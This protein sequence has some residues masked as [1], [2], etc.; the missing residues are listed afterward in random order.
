[1]P[2]RGWGRGSVV[3]CDGK[4]WRDTAVACRRAF[5]GLRASFKR[6][7]A[8]SPMRGYALASL[9]P[10]STTLARAGCPRS[11]RSD[12]D[13]CVDG[14]QR[15]RGVAPGGR[16]GD[17]N[18]SEDG[19]QRCRGVAHRKRRGDSNGSD[20]GVQDTLTQPP[21]AATPAPSNLSESPQRP[22]GAAPRRSPCRGLALAETGGDRFH[23][24]PGAGTSWRRAWWWE[25]R[26]LPWM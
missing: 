19:V 13:G 6:T 18:G 3:E 14:I 24:I 12:S 5:F 16:R 26:T 8:V 4:P 23:P 2:Q 22:L 20:H 1:M 15:W 7:T 11:W 21:H 25:V 9:P 10:H 17:S